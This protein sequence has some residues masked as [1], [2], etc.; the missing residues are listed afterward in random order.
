MSM[1]IALVRLRLLVV[2]VL[3]AALLSIRSD[4]F[5]PRSSNTLRLPLVLILTS[6]SH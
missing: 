6:D 5:L 2:L 3:L 4:L 1:S